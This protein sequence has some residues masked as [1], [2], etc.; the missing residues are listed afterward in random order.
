MKIITTKEKTTSIKLIKMLLNR[1][2]FTVD[3]NQYLMLNGS[4]YKVGK[5]YVHSSGYKVA[6]GVK[7]EPDDIVPMINPLSPEDEANIRLSFRVEDD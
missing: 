3:S 1:Y 5:Y 6:A 2:G 4:Y 7:E